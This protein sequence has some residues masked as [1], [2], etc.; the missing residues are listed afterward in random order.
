MPLAETPQKSVVLLRLA[1][2]VEIT[3]LPPSSVYAEMRDGDFPR[4][5]ALSANRV[6]WI[7]SEVQAWIRDRIEKYR[8]DEKTMP[9]RGRRAPKDPSSRKRPSSKR[10]SS[11]RLARVQR[12]GKTKRA[13]ARD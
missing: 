7:E 8:A 10:R 1:H 6:A 5:V 11:K 12:A 4:P 3:K 2:V 9:P 13:A